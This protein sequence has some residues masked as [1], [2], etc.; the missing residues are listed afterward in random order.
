MGAS[1]KS[2]ALRS[3]TLTADEARARSLSTAPGRACEPRAFPQGSSALP[4]L[5][6][7]DEMLEVYA[8]VFCQRGFRQLGVTFEQFLLVAAAIRPPDPTVWRCR[9]PKRFRSMRWNSVA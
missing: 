9:L 4:P 8:F 5:I 2:S 3:E 7:G 1:I 6:I